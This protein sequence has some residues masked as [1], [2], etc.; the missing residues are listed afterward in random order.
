MDIDTNRT[1]CS[2][3]NYS[4]TVCLAELQQWHY[5]GENNGPDILIPSDIDQDIVGIKAE[6]LFILIQILN[7]SK[8]CLKAFRSFICLHLFGVCDGN[9][10]IVQPSYEDCIQ[11]TTDT[12]VQEV[13]DINRLFGPE[14]LP[15]CVDFSHDRILCRKHLATVKSNSKCYR[16]IMQDMQCS[17]DHAGYTM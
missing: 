5:C 4:G 17:K 9:G 10:H 8:D 2:S 15:Q 16:N 14:Y 7:P 12:C 1:D 13:Q 11:L 6:Q 3:K